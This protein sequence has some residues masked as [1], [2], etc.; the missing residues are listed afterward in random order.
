MAHRILL[1]VLLLALRA[2]PAAAQAECPSRLFVSGYWS[3]VHVYDACTGAFL[4]ELDSRDR[5]QGAQAVRLG[6]DGLLY[7]ISEETSTIHKY[8]N[9]T[10]AYAGEFTRTGPT[11]PTGLAFDAAG[12]A[13]VGGYRTQDVRRYGR[14]GALSATVVAPRIPRVG[15][16]SSP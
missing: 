11:G 5:I 8:R 16:N 7:V 10:L 13:F 6:P 14:D 4:R 15:I 9:D 12:N 3:T 1:L 2:G